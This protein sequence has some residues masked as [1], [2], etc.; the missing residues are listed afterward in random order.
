MPNGK[1]RTNF[2]CVFRRNY[3]V[4]VTRRASILN[5][6]RSRATETY[7]A[8]D[9]VDDTT[10][11]SFRPRARTRTRRYKIINGRS[12]IICKRRVSELPS[13]TRAHCFRRISI[14]SSP[15]VRYRRPENGRRTL[16]ITIIITSV[17]V[18]CDRPDRYYFVFVRVN[19]CPVRPVGKRRGTSGGLMEYDVR[20]SSST[21][22]SRFN[23][24]TVPYA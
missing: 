11:L 14:F 18:V 23:A 8:G 3:S 20:S 6:N 15:S 9:D 7:T 24:A 19:V 21:I 10:V 16:R 1:R 2:D 17:A 13:E 5:R 12:D 22:V 4:C